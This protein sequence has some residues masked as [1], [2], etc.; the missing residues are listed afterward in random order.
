MNSSVN[1][2]LPLPCHVAVIGAAGGLG[3]GILMCAGE[4]TSHSRQLFARGRSALQAFRT[5]LALSLFPRSPI[6]LA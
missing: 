5:N 3:Q 2:P 4:R 6:A 1:L